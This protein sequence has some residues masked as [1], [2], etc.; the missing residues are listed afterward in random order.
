MIEDTKFQDI[1]NK[2][3]STIDTLKAIL[4]P[5]MKLLTN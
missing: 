5:L 4:M 1:V 3:T 2:L